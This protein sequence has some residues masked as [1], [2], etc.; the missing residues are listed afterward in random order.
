VVDYQPNVGKSAPVKTVYLHGII[1]ISSKV[2]PLT[3]YWLGLVRY[4][5]TFNGSGG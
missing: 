3:W 5:E 4:I 2:L 1:R